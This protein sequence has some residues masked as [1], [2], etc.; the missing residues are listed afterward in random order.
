[1]PYFRRTPFYPYQEE[2][3]SNA[4]GRCKFATDCIDGIT[5]M[6]YCPLQTSDIKCC[7]SKHLKSVQMINPT[8]RTCA[9]VGGICNH[10]NYDECRDGEVLFNL[11]NSC[12]DTPRKYECCVKNNIN[13]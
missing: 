12:P 9:E 10:V 3:C 5:K 11:S 6:N 1:M 2:K 13:L 4:G 8:I 7:I